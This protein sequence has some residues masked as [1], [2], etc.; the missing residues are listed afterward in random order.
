MTDLI[1][2]QRQFEMQMKLM[3]SAE[4]MDE[5]HVQLLRIV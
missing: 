2:H 4:E 5:K 1:N 3:K